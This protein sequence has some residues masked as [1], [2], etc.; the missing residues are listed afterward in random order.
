MTLV[1]SSVTSFM[2]TVG[3]TNYAMANAMLDAWADHAKAAGVPSQSIQWGA[4]GGVGM[5]AGNKLV[6]KQFAL[7]GLGV[8]HPGRGLL[9]LG[10]AWCGHSPLHGP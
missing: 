10:L 6:Q 3:Q 5:A 2:G 8:V 4:W 9:A 7:R 1:F